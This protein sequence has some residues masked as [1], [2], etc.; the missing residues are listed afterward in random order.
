MSFLTHSSFKEEESG[1]DSSVRESDT[2][3]ILRNITSRKFSLASSDSRMSGFSSRSRRFSA[4]AAQIT[5]VRKTSRSFSTYVSP[6][7]QKFQVQDLVPSKR[8][9]FKKDFENTYRMKPKQT[10]PVDEIRQIILKNLQNTVGE[11]VYSHLNPNLV[12]KTLSQLIKDQVKS[13]N[14]DRYK[15]VCLVTIGAKNRERVRVASRCLWDANFDRFAS[16]TVEN[17]SLFAV[18]TVYGLYYE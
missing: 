1:D 17:G 10:F 11:E 18:G 14:I 4:A 2:P 3:T 8:E 12:C 5:S 7:S 16:A 9:E 15:V 6:Y 13:L